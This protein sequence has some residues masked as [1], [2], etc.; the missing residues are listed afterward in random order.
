MVKLASKPAR[1]SSVSIS[2][3][4]TGPAQSVGSI[5]MQMDTPQAETQAVSSLGLE[6]DRSHRS[7]ASEQLNPAL[8]SS[9][10]QNWV[11]ES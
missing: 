8:A 6:T 9:G 3:G 1:A 2:T 11:L 4:K 5:P 10:R 7:A